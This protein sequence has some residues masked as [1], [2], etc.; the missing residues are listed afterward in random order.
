[1]LHGLLKKGLLKAWSLQSALSA[2]TEIVALF[3]SCA[4]LR[5]AKRLTVECLLERKDLECV[6]GV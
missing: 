1:M 2:K 3:F 5:E 4:E 6:Q